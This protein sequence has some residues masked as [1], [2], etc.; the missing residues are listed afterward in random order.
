MTVSRRNLAHR[1]AVAGAVVTLAAAPVG[2]QSIE[3]GYTSA[4]TDYWTI[5]R[6]GGPTVQMAVGAA[7]R[8]V[9]LVA[10]F[11]YLAGSE[12]SMGYRCDTP[13]FPTSSSWMPGPG[14]TPMSMGHASTLTLGSVGPRVT[15]L[16]RRGLE[17][18]GFAMARVG[19]LDVNSGNGGGGG[20]D[21]RVTVFGGDAGAALSWRPSVR[22]PFA[23][24]AS[25][26]AGS[27][28]PRVGAVN[29]DQPITNTMRVDRLMVGFA[30]R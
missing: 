18:A 24:T 27:L 12:R 17:L 30:W 4:A 22:L 6:L 14:C 2:A 21:G 29:S 10:G 26:S 8:R 9:R 15:L 23:A 19:S 16:R 5:G 28:T 11:E 7:G 13:Q 20:T 1:L 3:A 25:W